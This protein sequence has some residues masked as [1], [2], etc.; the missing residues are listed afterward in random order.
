MSEER[1]VKSEAETNAT[2]LECKTIVEHNMQREI[3][4]EERWIR[5]LSDGPITRLQPPACIADDFTVK[6]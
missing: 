5:R 4:R 2:D 6:A 1:T 3:P